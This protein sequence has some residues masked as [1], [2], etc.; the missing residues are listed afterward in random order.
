MQRL[1]TTTKIVKVLKR[2]P[3]ARTIV[4]EGGPVIKVSD[5]DSCAK[6][7]RLLGVRA[8]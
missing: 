6:V 1:I 7:L 2:G 3:Q 8:K 4:C 5:Q